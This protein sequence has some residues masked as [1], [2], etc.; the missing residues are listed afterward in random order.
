[1]RFV[2]VDKGNGTAQIGNTIYPF[3][4]SSQVASV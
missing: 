4:L 2:K 3:S 1:M